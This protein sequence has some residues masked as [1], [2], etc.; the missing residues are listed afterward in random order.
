MVFHS[1]VGE[2]FSF[3]TAVHGDLMHAIAFQSRNS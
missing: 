1:L 3:N 2:P